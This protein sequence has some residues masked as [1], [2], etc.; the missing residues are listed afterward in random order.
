MLPMLPSL[1]RAQESCGTIFRM[2]LPELGTWKLPTRNQPGLVQVWML[3]EMPLYLLADHQHVK[4]DNQVH[5]DRFGLSSIIWELGCCYG[6]RDPHHIFPISFNQ[7]YALFPFPFRWLCDDS[8]S[9]LN[10]G[11]RRPDLDLR[12]NFSFWQT[13][14][15]MILLLMVSS[16]SSTIPFLARKWYFLFYPLLSSYLGSITWTSI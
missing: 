11:S 2:V 7:L 13:I 3:S 5:G 10:Q 4:I 16:F 12:C 9:G 14:L 15:L 1:R 6:S 8:I